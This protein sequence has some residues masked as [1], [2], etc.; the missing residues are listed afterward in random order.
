MELASGNAQ[1][2]HPVG[3]DGAAAD[4]TAAPYPATSGC[5]G[6]CGRGG[7]GTKERKTLVAPG[8]TNVTERDRK[9]GFA[10][11]PMAEALQLIAEHTPG[12]TAIEVDTVAAAGL[13]LAEDVVATFPQP[14]FR[15]SIKDGYAVI[16]ADGPG[17]YEVVGSLCA[18]ATLPEGF[19]LAPGTVVRVNTG[20]PLPPGSDAVVQ[21]EDTELLETKDAPDADGGKEEARIRVSATVAAGHDIRPIGCDMQPGGIAVKAGATMNAPEIGLALSVGARKV[22]VMQKPRVA[23]ISTGDELS[24][25]ITSTGAPPPGKIYD[26]NRGMLIAAAQPYAR[27]VVD[28]G[29]ANDNMADTRRVLEAAFDAA[30]II[31]STGGVSM[32]EVDCVK[33]CLLEMGAD[34]H[35]GRVNMKPGKP[36]TFATLKGKVFFALPG[37]PVSAMVCFHVFTTPSLLKLSG[38]RR[39][40]LPTVQA[41]LNHE[42]RLDRER[43]EYHRCYVS[44]DMVVGGFSCKSTGIQ[45]SHRLLSLAGANGLMVLPSATEGQTSVAAGSKVKVMMIG[46]IQN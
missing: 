21:V 27:T 37:N 22:R 8:G 41:T 43:P 4:T 25:T 35:F 1:S 40:S 24:D 23:V 19:V 5:T 34:V 15:A 2:V 6:A 45:A 14:P 3:G 42:V 29:I 33:R 13:T 11:V 18:G 46:P 26:S 7:S 39:L 9:S 31:I 20:G 28:G 36:T 12:A 38:A 17:D 30:D 10:M 44:Y 32:G 16:A